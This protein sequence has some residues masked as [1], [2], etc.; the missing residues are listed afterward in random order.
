M[1]HRR[2]IVALALVVM[3][4]LTATVVYA[5]GPTR[6]DWLLAKRLTVQNAANLQSTLAVTSDTTVGG[7]L[8]VTGD[9]AIGGDLTVTG[10][11]N[12]GTLEC[13]TSNLG[14][15]LTV[16]DTLTVSGAT[17]LDGGLTMDTNKFTVADT[18]G[19]VATAG[20]L[21]QTL[22]NAAGGSA[23]PYDYTGTLGA[24]NGSDDFT[25][26]D[27][28]IT[29]ANHTGASNT[30]QALDIAAITGD[31]DATETAIKVGA[32]WDNGINN[33]SPTTLGSTLG[34]TG[35]ST[36]TGG[37]TVAA[38]GAFAPAATVAVGAG[39]TITPLGSNQPITSTASI[40]T[41]TSEAI[42]DGTVAGQLLIL[43]N[44]NASDT[45]T[46]DGTGGNVECKSDVVLGAQDTMMLLW[47]GA[48]WVCLS[49][50]D[51]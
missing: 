6:F 16:T 44:A 26:F 39:A 37:A 2:L 32:G 48:D 15:S 5:A 27:V 24:M 22:V 47:N 34:V 3:L 42:A 30:V 25:L 23:N 8:D 28:N 49:T 21:A 20:T 51:N 19:N 10:T 36:F 41:S 18:S 14:N 50:R 29:N 1:K 43:R 31:A 33:A 46:V 13:T 38:F 17:A 11:A 12:L 40:T 9:T 7:D 35:L 4:L 45:I